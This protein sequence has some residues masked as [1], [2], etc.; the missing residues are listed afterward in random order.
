MGQR[1]SSTWC[2]IPP[3]EAP[4]GEGDE[5]WVNDVE[6]QPESGELFQLARVEVHAQDGKEEEQCGCHTNAKKH[7]AHLAKTTRHTAQ[8]YSQAQ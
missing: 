7:N 3:A 1:T 5:Q 8:E 2:G 4:E 6:E